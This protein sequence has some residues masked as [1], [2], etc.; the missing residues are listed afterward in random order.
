MTFQ[1]RRDTL[2]SLEILPPELRS[3]AV[4]NLLLLSLDE[5]LS[6]VYEPQALNENLALGD[7]TSRA[8]IKE[9]R[10]L[11]GKLTAKAVGMIAGLPLFAAVCYLVDENIHFDPQIKDG[12]QVKPGDILAYINGPGRALL[13]AER[14]ALNFLGRM[15]G[16]ATLTQ[17]YVAQLAG[18]NATLLDTRKTL[19]GFRK[20]DKY[21]VR[22]GGGQNHRAGL[23]D[24]VM[25]KDN[26]IDGA[27][28]IE[29][30]VAGV[31][32]EFGDQYPIEVEVK[33][34]KEL[35]IALSLNIERIMLDNMSPNMMREAVVITA[36]RTELEAS[37]NVTLQT[38]K[39]IAE[40]GVDFISVG[41]LTHSVP[42][43]DISMR[44]I[45]AK[46]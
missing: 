4:I 7:I 30:A 44:L 29:A 36:K 45:E 5:D 21:A 34:L 33:N 15:S 18:T 22:M 27:G 40:T 26:H 19:P 24:M 37:G 16:V 6:G 13:T 8:T 28:S 43:L 42:V 20:L 41:A 32:R 14:T 9:D 10:Q 1:H 3:E 23:Y 46:S 35:E 17:Q 38:I 11:S 31:R 39:E 2:L 12:A 25:I